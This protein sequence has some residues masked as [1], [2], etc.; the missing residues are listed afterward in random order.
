MFLDIEAATAST[1]TSIHNLHWEVLE[2]MSVWPEKTNHQIIVR[3]KVPDL[4]I[5]QSVQTKGNVSGFNILLV[6]ARDLSRGDDEIG[7]TLTTAGMVEIIGKLPS[8]TPVNLEIVRPGTWDTLKR[9]LE[10]RPK[11]YFSIVHL[12]MPGRVNTGTKRSVNL[13][14]TCYS[15][16]PLHILT[17]RWYSASLCFISDLDYM[18][19]TWKS[20]KDVATLLNKHQ[21]PSV[22][23]N[24]C[25]S[26]DTS[27]EIVALTLINHGVSSVVA[28][29]Y[30]F[31]AEASRLFMSGFYR[32]LLVDMS[33]FAIAAYKGRKRLLDKN[34]RESGY[35]FRVPLEDHIVPVLYQRE[36]VCPLVWGKMAKKESVLVRYVDAPAKVVGRELDI[37]RLEIGLLTNSNVLPIT[38]KRGVG[39]SSCEKSF[40]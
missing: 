27:G 9:H 8:K 26:A 22:I 16:L 25:N 14:S 7:H 1:A 34:L 38:G 11:G 3:R 35:N 39:E 33:S 18:K 6:V 12:D 24:A 31:L 21:V 15:L 19:V 10:S 36:N 29:S 20:S 23:L 2:D 37:L 5:V 13:L 17:T 28:I 30:K 32:S 4:N 40:F